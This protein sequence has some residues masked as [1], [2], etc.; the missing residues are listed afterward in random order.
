MAT[1]RPH[2]QL[3]L[4]L[5]VSTFPRRPRA[6]ATLSGGNSP[7]TP[8]F[9]RPLP[10]HPAPYPPP[11]P[12]SAHSRSRAPRRARRSARSRPRPRARRGAVRP[13]RRSPALAP[14]RS[15]LLRGVGGSA[16]AQAGSGLG[17]RVLGVSFPLFWAHVSVPSP[18]L[19]T[20]S[21][22]SVPA[23][24]S[25]SPMPP[26]AQVP[27]APIPDAPRRVGFPGK[28]LPPLPCTLQGS[29]KLT[30]QRLLRRGSPSF[31]DS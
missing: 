10:R 15:R 18:T 7:G 28:R 22:V 9:C 8:S 1:P 23:G 2:K 6:L 5:L 14:F 17:H 27:A 16:G 3:P 11:R 4:L 19:P 25:D 26:A 12:R 30:F 21:V 24:R 29:R 13:G 20:P 31:S